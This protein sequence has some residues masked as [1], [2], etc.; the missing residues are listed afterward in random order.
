MKLKFVHN[1]LSN[2]KITK[3]HQK[4]NR[5]ILHVFINLRKNKNYRTETSILY[6]GL[7]TIDGQ[8]NVFSLN[9]YESGFRVCKEAKTFNLVD[10]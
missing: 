5:M 3:V 1:N 6:V 10:T 7:H 2:M 4:K 8:F 9:E